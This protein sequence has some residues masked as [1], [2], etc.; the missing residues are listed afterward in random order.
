M[1]PQV[2]AGLGSAA[3]ALIKMD[4]QERSLESL[5][6]RFILLEQKPYGLQAIHSFLLRE[7]NN[8]SVEEA[9]SF[10]MNCFKTHKSTLTS[11]VKLKLITIM[12][13]IMEADDRVTSRETDFI[14]K[15]K[16]DLRA[17]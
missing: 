6:V 13:K 12:E 14:E 10:A 2:F 1:S 5:N 9:Y 17:V 15:F 3:Y 8:S 4:G 11:D 7:H 16:R